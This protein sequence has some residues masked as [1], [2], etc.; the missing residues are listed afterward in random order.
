MKLLKKIVFVVAA[1]LMLVSCGGASSP[2]DVAKKFVEAT[3]EFDFKEAKKYVAK[4]YADA[5]DQ[6]IEQFSSPEAQ[7]YLKIFKETA[8]GTKVEVL[9]EKISEDGNSAVVTVKFEMMGQSQEEELPLI[10]EDG[11]WKI[12]EKPS[13]GK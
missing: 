9:G 4:E 13:A 3:K 5:M 6:I 11:A 2:S 10:L 7:G 8:K 1:G 12:N